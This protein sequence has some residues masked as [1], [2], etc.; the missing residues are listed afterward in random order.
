MM[1]KC[2][3][4]FD[5]FVVLE[6]AS[7]TINSIKTFDCL[8]MICQWF[9]YLVQVRQEC[10]LLSGKGLVIYNEDQRLLTSQKLKEEEKQLR[11]KVFCYLMMGV[12]LCI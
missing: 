6:I 10:Q 5:E 1:I 7:Y 9:Y 3:I 11:A 12:L 8:I 4:S 2:N